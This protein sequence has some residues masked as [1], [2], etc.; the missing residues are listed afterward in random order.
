MPYVIS[1]GGFDG[2]RIGDAENWVTGGAVFAGGFGGSG[3]F[4]KLLSKSL[5][6]VGGRWLGIGASDGDGPKLANDEG[7]G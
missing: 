3:E 6:F 2:G 1:G 5:E 4:M 7:A